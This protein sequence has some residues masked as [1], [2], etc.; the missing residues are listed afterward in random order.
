[1]PE[2]QSSMPDEVL[3]HI[4]SEEGGEEIIA[5]SV[6][7]DSVRSEIETIDSFALKLSVLL[8]QP[9][10][11]VKHMV[12]RLPDTLWRGK[13][14]AK[15]KKL[16][17]LIEEA[18]GVARIVE[19]HSA[20]KEAAG[21]QERDGTV[22]RKCGFPLKPEDEYCSFC[23]T[24]LKESNAKPASMPAVVKSPAIPHSRMIFYLIVLVA[25]VILAFVLR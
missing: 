22:C 24:A 9:V 4:V 20:P 23:M 18:G 14:I 11:K 25:V 8:K 6:V 10:T 17:E 3:Q 1:M 2:K 16:I 12:R 13:S 5:Y 21:G 7:L 15:A 19:D